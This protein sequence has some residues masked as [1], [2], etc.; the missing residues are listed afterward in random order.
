MLTTRT[1]RVPK[2]TGLLGGSWTVVAQAI[3]RRGD[4]S[5]ARRSSS[6]ASI[7]RRRWCW[8]TSP[9][10]PTASSRESVAARTRSRR[11]RA[12]RC[13]PPRSTT[14]LA[15]RCGRRSCSTVSPRDVDDQTPDPLPTGTRTPGRRCEGVASTRAHSLD[16][17]LELIDSLV[18][19]RDPSDEGLS[20]ERK[21]GYDARVA[22]VL[23]IDPDPQQQQQPRPR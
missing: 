10:L 1:A 22:A 7:R 12:R 2:T 21:C 17:E 14:R 18:A 3:D 11:S 23:L 6:A 20:K 13:T 19:G 9:V 8:A 4:G 15:R 16:D 5:P